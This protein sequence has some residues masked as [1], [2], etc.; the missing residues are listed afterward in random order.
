[1]KTTLLRTAFVSLLVFA[2]GI[3]LQAQSNPPDAHLSGT[4]I[5]ASGGGVGGVQ[6]T[7]RPEGQPNAQTWSAVST[8][9]G[10]YSLAV[11]AGR[12]HVRF[13]RPPFISRD[14]VVV[15]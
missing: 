5:D 1:M 2:V 8:P 9:A 15:R 14:F 10:E 13:L 4:L 6:V 11:P 12:C 7:A 3:S